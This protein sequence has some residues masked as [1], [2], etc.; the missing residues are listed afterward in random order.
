MTEK[1]HIVKKTLAESPSVMDEIK[2]KVAGAMATVW[3][4]CSQQDGNH[5]SS[6]KTDVLHGAWEKILKSS[7]GDYQDEF[8]ER[9]SFTTEKAK[10]GKTKKVQGILCGQGRDFRVDMALYEGN[11]IH[12]V[13]LLK[14][15]MTSLN[16]NK[17][18]NEGAMIGEINRFYSNP[19]NANIRLVFVNFVP[20]NTFSVSKNIYAPE[21]TDYTGF[22]QKKNGT[23]AKDMCVIDNRHKDKILEVVVLYDLDFSQENVSKKDAMKKIKN[24]N[25]LFDTIKNKPNFITVIGSGIKDLSQYIAQFVAENKLAVDGPKVESLKKQLEFKF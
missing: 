24:R 21:K 2:T 8:E 1:R 20:E 22:C 15:H 19:D 17:F 9:F 5:R 3:E 11:Q 13:Y 23:S 18:N 4:F 6:S 7:F 10:N 25:D 16:K 12:T 14:A